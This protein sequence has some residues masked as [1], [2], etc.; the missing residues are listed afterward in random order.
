[1]KI[2]LYFL[3]SGEIA[4]PVLDRIYRSDRFELLGVCTQRDRPAGRSKALLPT[5][6][7]VW[8]QKNNVDADKPLSVNDSVF[9]SKVKELAPDIILV[10][11]FGQILKETFLE[12]PKI[13]CVNV[14][15]SL[16]PKYRGAS[17][18]T[19]AIL[20]ADSE[21]GVCFMK[22][23]KGLDNGA[24]YKEV[25]M[26]LHG[27][28]YA[29]ELELNL[30]KLAAENTEETIYDIFSGKIYPKKQDHS[31]A[32]Y[33]GKIKKNDGFIDWNMSA[34][35]IE[36]KIRAFYPWPGA[37]FNINTSKGLKKINIT[38]G[39]VINDLTGRAG[40][41]IKSDKTGWII[42]CGSGALKI[43]RLIPEG[44]KEMAGEDFLLGTRI[45][46][47]SFVN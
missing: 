12:I 39:E 46:A 1:M 27:D 20:N 6:V 36:R 11:S 25:K 29:D 13:S 37:Y 7:G 2:K 32:S 43:A 30:G 35:E 17:P 18:I 28:E 33:V 24:V 26:S 40:E 10:I 23:E 44:K 22:M 14:H 38:A 4:V 5:P 42:S 31:R 34:M 45:E 21:A 19:S 47:G 16:L 41:V 15:A 8:A 9:I 3:G